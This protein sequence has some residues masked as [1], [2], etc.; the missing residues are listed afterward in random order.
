MKKLFHENKLFSFLTIIKH[1]F[2]L[3]FEKKNNYNNNTNL[4]CLE[5]N[6]FLLRLYRS[7][8]SHIFHKLKKSLQNT[9]NYLQQITNLCENTSFF[10]LKTLF[11]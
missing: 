8:I 7:I 1:S 10:F 4:W 3:C 5:K 9:I 11:C 6:N 2:S